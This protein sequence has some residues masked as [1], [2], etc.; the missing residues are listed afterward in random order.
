[1]PKSIN[2]VLFDKYSIDSFAACY[3]A[4][5]TLGEDA[6]YV[7]IDRST[8]DVEL[9]QEVDLR[10]KDIALLGISRGYEAM[11]SLHNEC[12]TVLVLENHQSAK[13]DLDQLVYDNL[14]IVV[15]SNMGAGAMA[16]NFFHPSEPV[17]RLVRYIEDA[18]LGREVLLDAAAFADG[19]E[20]TCPLKPPTGAIQSKDEAF[21]EFEHYL[22]GGGQ[23]FID[24]AIEE[25]RKLQEEIEEQALDAVGN[26]EIKVLRAF[27]AWR[28]AV[29]NLSSPLVGR[30]AERCVKA[31]VDKS[32]PNVAHRCLAAN[33]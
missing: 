26:S 21:L 25:G 30:I 6:E 13:Q 23:S 4:R 5:A 32:E 1:M 8:T 19:L 3:A 7:G 17:P 24:E 31:M 11:H 15:D 28:C 33:I 18:D 16:W 9:E 14:A 27:P 29:V 2:V 10:D 22:E 20:A 12:R